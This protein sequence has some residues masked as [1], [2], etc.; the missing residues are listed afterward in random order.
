VTIAAVIPVLLHSLREAV[1]RAGVGGLS[2]RSPA[3][4]FSATPPTPA[5][6]TT[7]YARVGR[8][9]NHLRYSAIPE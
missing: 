1:G 7:R 5:L 6:P 9:K 8:E 2:T 4:E 3:D